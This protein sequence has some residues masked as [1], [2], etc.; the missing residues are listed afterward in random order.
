MKNSKWQTVTGIILLLALLCAILFN[1][2]YSVSIDRFSLNLNRVGLH[3]TE[4]GKVAFSGAYMGIEDAARK[5]EPVSYYIPES[6]RSYLRH[7]GYCWGYTII[8]PNM[9]LKT[10]LNVSVANARELSCI[11]YVNKTIFNVTL[12]NALMELRVL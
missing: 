10:V 1:S 12:E 8:N 2:V 4:E 5:K 3:L 9:N 7:Y 6:P 11:R